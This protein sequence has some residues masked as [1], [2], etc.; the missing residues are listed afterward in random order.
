MK[1]KS[2]DGGTW[3]VSRRWVPWRRRTK[4]I[5]SDYLPSSPSGDDP[6]SAVISVILLILAIPVLIAALVVALELLLLLLLLPVA[7]VLRV[8]FGRRWHVEVRQGFKPHWEQASGTW[9]QSG[10]RIHVIVR[11]IADGNLP[12]RTVG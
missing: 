12:P 5:S 8:L 1:V 11:E 4:T 7:V 3:R 6:I 10:A 2:P 9:K